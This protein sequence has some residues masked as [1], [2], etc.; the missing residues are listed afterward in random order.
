MPRANKKN[1]NQKWRQVIYV[2]PTKSLQEDE[3]LSKRDGL[4]R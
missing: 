1:F 3:H 2:L 4:T